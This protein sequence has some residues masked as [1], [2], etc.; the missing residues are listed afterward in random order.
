[1]PTADR[2]SLFV[3]H[4]ATIWQDMYVRALGTELAVTLDQVSQMAEEERSRLTLAKYLHTLSFVLAK[5]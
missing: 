2:A 1:M 5:S 4:T 3:V